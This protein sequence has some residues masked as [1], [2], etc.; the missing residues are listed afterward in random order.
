MENQILNLASS[1]GIW[2]VLSV[3]L[4]FYILKAQERRDN[5]QEE[6]EKE[7]YNLIISLIDKF[8]AVEKVKRNVDVKSSSSR[9]NKKV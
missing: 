5:K 1:Q 7:Y 3:I 8:S 2:A 4:I 9:G 6:R